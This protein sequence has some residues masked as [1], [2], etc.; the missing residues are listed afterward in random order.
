MPDRKKLYHARIRVAR[1]M[2]DYSMPALFSFSR[3]IFGVLL[4]LAPVLQAGPWTTLKDGE[5]QKNWI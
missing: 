5:L 2:A 3:L 4:L 1:R